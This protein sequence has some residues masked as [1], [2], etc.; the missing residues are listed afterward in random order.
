M[1]FFTIYSTRECNNFLLTLSN[2]GEGVDTA[3]ITARL[4]QDAL[5]RPAVREFESQ[6]KFKIVT[7]ITNGLPGMIPCDFPKCPFLA[8]VPQHSADAVDHIPC[9]F[10]VPV[11]SLAV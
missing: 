9:R 3:R 8:A 5:L 11:F 1:P 4:T 7:R 10:A 6:E 2:D